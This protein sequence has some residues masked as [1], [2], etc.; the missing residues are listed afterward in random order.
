MFETILEQYN[1]SIENLSR[2]ITDTECD[3]YQD[4][5]TEVLNLKRDVANF[6][7]AN[8]VDVG[9]YILR[10]SLVTLDQVVKTFNIQEELRPVKIL[11]QV[12]TWSE[13][14]LNETR[15]EQTNLLARW[16][17]PIQLYFFLPLTKGVSHGDCF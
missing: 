7:I 16:G 8:K 12:I 10:A 4:L 17:Y 15:N 11:N 9:T 3:P 2:R 1:E 14:I 13:A 6:I 5:D